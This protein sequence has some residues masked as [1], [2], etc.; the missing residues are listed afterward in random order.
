MGTIPLM[1][2]SRNVPYT[3]QAKFSIV[4]WPF[5]FKVLYAP[6]VDT[7]YFKRIGR[8]K[9]WLI[10]LQYLIAIFLFILSFQIDELMDNV[11]VEAITAVFFILC[12]LAASQDITVDGWAISMLH[13]KNVGY[14]SSCNA[15][16]QT[17]I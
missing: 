1:L 7:F 16:G 2:Q 4:G 6:I 5:S 11:N 8:R 15:V 17:V 3:E 9:S 10:P 14:A 13:P 12:L